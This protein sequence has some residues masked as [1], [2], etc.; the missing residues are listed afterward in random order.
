MILS[1]VYAAFKTKTKPRLPLFCFSLDIWTLELFAFPLRVIFCHVMKMIINCVI[2]HNLELGATN[3][4]YFCGKENKFKSFTLGKS[5]FHELFLLFLSTEWKIL[6]ETT[7]M[8]VVSSMKLNSSCTTS[9]KF[10]LQKL[11]A[12]NLSIWIYIL[13]GDWVMRWS[14]FCS[15]KWF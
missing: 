13:K 5:T 15:L 1:I 10:N 14:Y 8:K 11:D 9:T 2:D 4:L 3:H 12:S 6:F 7:H